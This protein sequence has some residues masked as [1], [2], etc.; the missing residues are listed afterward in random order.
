[1]TVKLAILQDN[2]QVIS[3]IKELVDDGKPVGYL[4]KNPHK[5]VINQPFLVEKVD[6]DTSIQV[7]LTPWILLT[8]DTEIVIPGNQVL[9]IVEPITSVKQMYLAV[10]YTHPEPTRP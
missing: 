5:V 3:E 2:E 10:S 9:T 4:L 1:M 8:S 7:T 6:D